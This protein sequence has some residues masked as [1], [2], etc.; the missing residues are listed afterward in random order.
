MAVARGAAGTSS[1]PS[2]TA[3][4]YRVLSARVAS[5]D[6]APAGTPQP[7]L[8]QANVPAQARENTNWYS[9]QHSEAASASVAGLGER[10][11]GS[12]VWGAPAARGPSADLEAASPRAPIAAQGSSAPG[13]VP[14]S[15]AAQRAPAA[16]EVAATT[17]ARPRPP[18][19]LLCGPGPP[20][21]AASSSALATS[22]HARSIGIGPPPSARGPA[23]AS[24]QAAAPRKTLIRHAPGP[25]IQPAPGPGIQ[26]VP[27]SSPRHA[28]GSGI[29]PLPGSYP[30]SGSGIHHAPGPGMQAAPGAG[31]R[32]APGAG[33]QTAA[34]SSMQPGPRLAP[35][36]SLSQPPPPQALL[37]GATYAPA[38]A[39]AAAQAPR[40]QS[41]GWY[42]AAPSTAPPQYLPA[43][44][45][46]ASPSALAGSH[47]HPAVQ[48]PQQHRVQ[49]PPGIVYPAF[50]FAPAYP[51]MPVFARPQPLSA[52]PGG[53]RPSSAPPSAAP[54]PGA[55]PAR[56]QAAP[57]AAPAPG[58][59][60]APE[61]AKTKAT[62]PVP[63]SQ[64][65]RPAPAP[66]RAA[67]AARPATPPD[68][69]APSSL[70][71]GRIFSAPAPA[72]PAP[73]RPV[74][75]S[76]PPPSG[77]SSNLRAQQ[78]APDPVSPKAAPNPPTGPG[79]PANRTASVPS[80][81]PEPGP[82][83]PTP[84][85]PSP[86]L[87]PLESL[88]PFEQLPDEILVR[89]LQPLVDEGGPAGALRGVGRASR[90]LRALCWQPDWF[91]EPSF[92]AGD[93]AGFVLASCRR[94]REYVRRLR[95]G[96]IARLSAAD[97]RS[98]LP[99]LQNLTHLSLAF[100][101]CV[102]RERIHPAPP[103]LQ[104][105]NLSFAQV[106]RGV[107]VDLVEASAASLR[108][109]YISST[110]V[111]QGKEGRKAPK[112]AL[113]SLR[114]IPL[115]ALTALDASDTVLDEAAAEVLAELAEGSPRLSFLY[116]C[117]PRAP[118]PE[119]PV[120]PP[121][122]LAAALAPLR[123]ARPAL[124]LLTSG[125]FDD[126]ELAEVEQS[127]A[128]QLRLVEPTLQEVALGLGPCAGLEAV[129]GNGRTP[130]L[131]AVDGLMWAVA[132]RLLELGAS[133]A[134]LV[135]PCGP[136]FPDPFV[137]PYPT[138]LYSVSDTSAQPG[139]NA[140][141]LLAPCDPS[142]CHPADLPQI[143]AGMGLGPLANQPAANEAGR[144]PL[145]VMLQHPE[146]S[147]SIPVLRAL[148]ALG[149]DPG[150]RGALHALAARPEEDP[151]LAEAIRTIAEAR[152][153]LLESLD[154][155]GRTPLVA[156]LEALAAAR[157]AEAEAA[158]EL[159]AEPCG[160]AAAA[161]AARPLRPVLRLLVALATPAALRGALLAAVRCRLPE[162]AEIAQLR[163]DA[164]VNER[165]GRGR[166]ALHAAL[167]GP[168]PA[169]PRFLH[170]LL[171]LPGVDASLADLEGKAPLHLAAA[172]AS[173]EALRLLLRAGADPAARDRAGRTPLHAAAA[174]RRPA[175]LEARPPLAVTALW[176]AVEGRLYGAAGALLARGADPLLGPPDSPILFALFAP[177][178]RRP[179]GPAE[180]RAEDEPAAAEAEAGAGGEEAEEVAALLGKL[181]GRGAALD[182]TD[183]AGRT[184]AHHYGVAEALLA[185]GCDPR[186][187]D[188]EGA[189][190]L[191]GLRF[192]AGEADWRAA[193]ALLE[194]LLRARPEAAGAADLRG[195]TP[196]HRIARRQ[197]WRRPWAGGPAA[198]PDV[199]R[200]ADALV[201]ASP[202]AARDAAGRTPLHVAAAGRH[203]G[204]LLRALLRCGRESL[205]ELLA[206]RDS[207]GATP[208]HV[209]A[210]ARPSPPWP[211]RPVC[212]PTPA[213]QLGRRGPLLALLEAHGPGDLPRDAA[214][215]PHGEVAPPALR[216]MLQG[217]PWAAGDREGPGG[218][219]GEAAAG[220]CGAWT[221]R[222]SDESEDPDAL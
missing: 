88:S 116:I 47:R 196:L 153:R 137:A 163:P 122:D 52:P 15:W 105:L 195:R 106:A 161:A 4:L 179:A 180:G 60:A 109:L 221:G 183:G 142:E 217:W 184:L 120:A 98:L 192:G 58:P 212:T 76:A 110:A 49:Y 32:P 56:P 208:L 10:S 102:L 143:L 204:L 171:Q 101:P 85:P 113:G 129:D 62:A 160:T 115:P 16:A 53:A 162:F 169:P 91:E 90:R 151:T 205:R 145:E 136:L 108:A 126:L 114:A 219:A 131:R 59:S 100:A 42:G 45:A 8:A 63:P 181:L 51:I 24:S 206:A 65:P 135:R 64:E 164:D 213:A 146:A 194:A 182:A 39:A 74:L 7:Q 30:A 159:E 201:A 71:S 44:A 11:R 158:A 156:A 168:A 31:I 72:A 80:P 20:P 94:M 152:P 13:L 29:N 40:L 28:S 202:L 70:R 118:T 149:A 17:A 174:A 54:A 215:R 14:H 222:E 138:S 95:A 81:P 5:E 127:E 121:G 68:L 134:A 191:H 99:P 141:H 43:P 55:A 218:G 92:A 165:D 35:P 36:P 207:G 148:L 87:P 33:I 37:P 133:Q 166:T 69:D 144:T 18:P 189:T 86:P 96:H 1:T 197:L 176:L 112:S 147:F 75:R 25:G 178:P 128:E 190:A 209:A 79:R 50:S 167:E 73:H 103:S 12:P 186:A 104:V 111:F 41:P 89:I 177:R 157:A 175:C 210:R 77:P 124:R 199:E 185:A 82:S 78:Q 19:P 26:A 123:A 22:A 23:A 132:G 188:A 2:T 216:R 107:L 34:G 46:Q 97:F 125:A 6:A 67:P 9:Q 220:A 172:A 187:A 38:A 198:L 21:H 48:Y 27:A 170:A 83:S 61:A 66:A 130:F 150:R 140:L 214:G 173:P 117:R 200:A 155:E 154:E 203:V 3:Q 119:L 139:E 84:R 93:P 211:A 57:K 193:C